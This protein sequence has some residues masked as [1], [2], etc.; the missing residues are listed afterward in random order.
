M[1]QD[2]N[3][4]VVPLALLLLFGLALMM[5]D[6][7]AQQG[8]PPSVNQV[9]AQA[10]AGPSFEAGS[11]FDAARPNAPSPY[12]QA[13][14]QDAAPSNWPPPQQ[15]RP[16]Y[17][18]RPPASVAPVPADPAADAYPVD[19]ESTEEPYVD[20]EGEAHTDSAGQGQSAANAASRK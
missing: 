5:V 12:S 13:P 17:T 2:Q 7:S 9:G 6:S 18:P 8:P 1:G 11:P 10:S 19:E 4:M 14:Y 20:G 15:T 16:W 3:F